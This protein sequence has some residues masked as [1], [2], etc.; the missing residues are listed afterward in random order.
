[1]SAAARNSLLVDEEEED[2]I[3]TIVRGRRNSFFG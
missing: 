1:M 2:V 3:Q